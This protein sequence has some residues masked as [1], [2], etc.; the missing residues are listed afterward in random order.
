MTVLTLILGFLFGA[1]LQY[2]RLNRYNTISGMAMLKDLTMAKAIAVA[3]GLG[4][5]LVNIE[6]GLG[7]ASYHVKPVILGGLIIGGLIFG[8]GMAIL[9]YCPGTIPVSMGEGSLDAVTGLIGGLAAGLIYTLMIPSINAI[10]GPN[11]GVISAKTLIPE[12]D[13]L[14]YL[15]VIVLGVAMIAAA[16]ALNRMEKANNMRWLYSGIGIAVLTAIIF[17]SS[18]TNRV[19]GASSTYPYVACLIGGATANE[20]FRSIAGAGKWEL[21][22]LSGAF[23]S[24]LVLSIIR[25]DFKLTLI[26][27]N[28]RK[29]KGT[30][31]AGRVAWAFVGGFLLI[32]G[33]RL[34]GGCTSG[35][36]IS[37][38]IQLA[39]SSYLF[40][41]VVFTAFLTT[42]RLFYKR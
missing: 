15:V 13:T 16:F 24:G 41:A 38:G 22:F 17:L 34:A 37:G 36:I 5:I 7:F 35:H 11:L 6:I 10:T 33:A 21:I 39:I 25:K 9:G 2:S 8:T 4:I 32:F 3:I 42:G 12:S 20:Y 18:T 29:Y 26:H 19:L 14:F 28:W 27:D 30:S 31:N 40:A 1:A 23:L